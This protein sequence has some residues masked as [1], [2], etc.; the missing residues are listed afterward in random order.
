VSFLEGRTDDGLLEDL[1]FAC[2]LVTKRRG[3]PDPTFLLA[4]LQDDTGPGRRGPPRDYALL[5]VL[6][7]VRAVRVG[8][9]EVQLRAEPSIVP[10]LRAGRVS[11]AVEVAS[12]RLRASALAPRKV[13][14]DALADPA[15]GIR[16]AASLLIPVNRPAALLPWVRLSTEGEVDVR[17]A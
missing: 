5:E 16:L 2:F 17:G 15:R 9:R 14:V 1:L 6:F 8:N 3:R 4:S 7:G 12:R 10:L 13:V 11:D